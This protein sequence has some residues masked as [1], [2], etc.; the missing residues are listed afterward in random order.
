MAAVMLFS[1]GSILVIV[2]AVLF[3]IISSAIK[4]SRP[5]AKPQPM[6]DGQMPDVQEQQQTQMEQGAKSENLES[7]LY[8]SRNEQ[9]VKQ[10]KAEP[11]TKLTEPECD[12]S[13]MT[14][15]DMRKAVV[16]SEILN[17]KY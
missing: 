7:R 17:R 9:E 4:K 5:Q 12:K 3:S 2:F 15:D 14:A 1:V 6:A 16:M 10:Q 8:N 11:E 13:G